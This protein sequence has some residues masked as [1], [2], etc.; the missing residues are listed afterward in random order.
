M[1]LEMKRHCFFTYLLF[2]DIFVS[3]NDDRKNAIFAIIL[4]TGE[5]NSNIK[6]S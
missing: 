5:C 3:F 4:H 1:I 6:L 2:C